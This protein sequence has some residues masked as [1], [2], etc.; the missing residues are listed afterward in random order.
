MSDSFSIP[1]NHY[2]STN[3]LLETNKNN[4][5]YSEVYQVPGIFLNKNLMKES[6]KPI[7]VISAICDRF[8]NKPEFCENFMN[9]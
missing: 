7:I 1:E 8:L 9:S 2:I 6:L 5:E 3:S 4:Y